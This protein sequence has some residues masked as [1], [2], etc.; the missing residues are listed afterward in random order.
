[1]TIS[2]A[3]TSSKVTAV[4]LGAE[5]TVL[6]KAGALCRQHGAP[7]VRVDQMDIYIPQ[8]CVLR[9]AGF[10]LLN[11]NPESIDERNRVLPVLSALGLSA[12]SVLL[13]NDCAV[14][15]FIV[16]AYTARSDFERDSRFEWD[17]VSESATVEYTID[18]PSAPNVTLNL[19]V[20]ALSTEGLQRPGVTPNDMR[21][22]ARQTLG[23]DVAAVFLEPYTHRLEEDFG[24]PTK[25]R[26]DAF[27]FFVMDVIR[28]AQGACSVCLGKFYELGVYGL[29]DAR[30]QAEHDHVRRDDS[31]ANPCR[32]LR[33]SV[34]NDTGP[35]R[36][37]ENFVTR[38]LHTACH[39]N[40]HGGSGKKGHKKK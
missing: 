11:T 25:K 16:S 18:I 19:T 27:T 28:L 7:A 14:I 23:A 8:V 1:M 29:Q 6:A 34:M 31:T 35:K 9:Y 21:E 36:I 2:S 5:R 38:A 15:E 22:F 33:A 3:S 10:H 13:R 30:G 4:S 12:E 37:G 26:I 40:T 17:G 39:D 32:L 20:R 24:D